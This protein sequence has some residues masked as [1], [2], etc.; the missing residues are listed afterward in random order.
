M[1]EITFEVPGVSCQHCV[2]AITKETQAVG[3]QTV[4]VD[5]DSKQVYT[6]F[7]ESKVSPEQVREAIEEAGY[8]VA[9][10][11]AGRINAG[12]QSLKLV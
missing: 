10:Q 1:K 2:D 7:D 3:V 8:D 4:Q 5:L 12:K 9:G 6:T 11:Q